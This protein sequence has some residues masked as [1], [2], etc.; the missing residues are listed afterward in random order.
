MEISFRAWSS[1]AL[2]EPELD[3][4]LHMQGEGLQLFPKPA[5][6]PAK[7]KPV[8]LRK[9]SHRQDRAADI[10]LDGEACPWERVGSTALR[11]GIVMISKLNDVEAEL[12]SN[13]V[14]LQRDVNAQRVQRAAAG[15]QAKRHAAAA[16]LREEKNMLHS[17]HIIDAA[18]NEPA[19]SEEIVVEIAALLN[20]RL[21]QVFVDPLKR[22]WFK[23]FRQVDCDGS[24]L[25]SFGEFTRM[26]RVELKVS[27]RDLP[28]ASL[29]AVWLAFDSDGSGHIS[30]GEFGKFM[31]RGGTSG[32]LDAYFGPS[33]RVR[34]A[35]ASPCF[36]LDASA[37]F[38]LQAELHSRRACIAGYELAAAALEQ[39]L[40]NAS[41]SGRV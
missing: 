7:W 24:G 16:A 26:V 18:R 31:R 34:E 25:I 30:A 3:F 21:R 33:T 9:H 17:R 36:K 12:K 6:E 28:E 41:D 35:D 19:A 14:R 40:F 13:L 11:S 23:L 20:V 1:F 29:R 22:S 37:V 27:P 38:S 5:K 8:M 39:E 4:H 2:Q 15:V 10:E 32:Q